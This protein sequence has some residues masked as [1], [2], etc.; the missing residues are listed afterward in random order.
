MGCYDRHC[1]SEAHILY[2]VQVDWVLIA[3]LQSES[4]LIVGNCIV[5]V[6]LFGLITVP[7]METKHKRAHC[8]RCEAISVICAW[9]VIAS[10][11]WTVNIKNIRI[12]LFHN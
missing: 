10:L 2:P 6:V 8:F 12:S 11:S 5:K 3:F 1:L 9:E 7:E 4:V